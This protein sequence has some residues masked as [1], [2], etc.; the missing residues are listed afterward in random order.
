MSAGSRISNGSSA[1]SDGSVQGASR[2]AQTRSAVVERQLRR[3]DSTGAPE[4]CLVLQL[5]EENTQN[6]RTI[7]MLIVTDELTREHIVLLQNHESA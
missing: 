2:A 6:E 1:F 7:G 3:Q 4:E 5:F